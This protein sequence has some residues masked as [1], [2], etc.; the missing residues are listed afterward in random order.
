MRMGPAVRAVSDAEVAVGRELR[1]VGQRHVAEPDVFHICERLA[2][3]SDRHV[4]GLVA[5]GDRYGAEL[6]EADGTPRPVA[7]ARRQLSRAT[8]RTDKTGPLLLKD[9][10]K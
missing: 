2:D 3:Q 4:H 1:K 6:S 7:A 5:V 10:R 8:A 9:L